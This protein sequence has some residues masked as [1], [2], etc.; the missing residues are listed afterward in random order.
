MCQTVGM[1]FVAMLVL[2]A[3]PA[4]AANPD[5]F[6]AFV[7]KHEVRLFELAKKNP[8]AA[9]TELQ[10][11]LDGADAGRGA[12]IELSLDPTAKTKS[13]IVVTADGDRARFADVRRVVAAAPTL[14][15]WDV[16]AFRQRRE[17][18][19]TL[20][21]GG[22]K[23]SVADFQFRE[24]RRHAGQVDLEV[25]VRGL[26]QQTNAA[27][28]QAAFIMMDGV[29]GEYDMETKVGSIDF[30]ALPTPAPTGLRP[31]TELAKVVDSLTLSK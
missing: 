17:P 2:L 31:L 23:V 18:S 27:H 1:R 14:K 13:L 5:S 26:T 20:E 22:L 7:A 19:H 3:G 9:M 25:F 21:L 16:V 8:V 6:W 28:Q 10:Q 24:V 4:L 30:L 29:V 11:H 12:I 15:Q